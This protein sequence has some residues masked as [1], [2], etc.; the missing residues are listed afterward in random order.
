MWREDYDPCS[1]PAR[2]AQ[3][4][5]RISQT[6]NKKPAISRRDRADQPI[7]GGSTQKGP[8][9][10]IL[11][12]TNMSGISKSG[13][14]HSNWVHTL[15][16]WGPATSIGLKLEIYILYELRYSTQVLTEHVRIHHSQP[17]DSFFLQRVFLVH[18][19][20][21]DSKASAHYNPSYH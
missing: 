15:L 13:A 8:V 16:I 1:G 2:I 18:I 21:L 14:Y 19:Y 4:R 20:P 10:L 6:S 11:R 7:L 17:D 3:H 9:Q 12:P 5:L